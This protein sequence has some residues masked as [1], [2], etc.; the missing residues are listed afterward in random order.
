MIKDIVDLI[1]FGDQTWS[2]IQSGGI[3]INSYMMLSCKWFLSA[4]EFMDNY[5]LKFTTMLISTLK[6]INQNKAV[7]FC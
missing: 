4:N 3:D 1:I 6:S 2:L 5:H 7:K